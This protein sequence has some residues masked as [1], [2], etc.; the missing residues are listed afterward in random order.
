MKAPHPST[1]DVLN[2]ATRRA[3]A[4]KL[5]VWFRKS[6]RD[7]P[8]RGTDDP[9][10][11]WVSEIMLQQTQVTTVIPY[12]QRF[13]AAFPNVALLASADEEQVLRLWEGLGY[14]RRARQMHAAARQIAAQHALTSAVVDDGVVPAVTRKNGSASLKGA[15]IMDNTVVAVSAVCIP[16]DTSAD[17]TAGIVA[18]EDNGVITI[19]A[20]YV[21]H[22][23]P[24][25]VK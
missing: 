19:I 10:A 20:I 11:I 23:G 8:W 9:Y 16:F 2:P 24:R 25:R 18:I 15:L 14:Y 6:A 13:L 4:R 5:L 17:H 7:L 21:T 3:L 12:Y 1:L 22:D